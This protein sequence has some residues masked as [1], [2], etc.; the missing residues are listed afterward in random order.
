MKFKFITLAFISIMVGNVYAN[1]FN[2]E[3]TYDKDLIDKYIDYRKD[4]ILDNIEPIYIKGQKHKG[5]INYVSKKFDVPIEVFALPAIE[6]G[7]NYKARSH[8][9]AIGMWQIMKP[10]GKD[11][12][13]YISS[14]RDERRNWK[15]STVA[16]IKYLR[17]L[18]VDF[19]EG[20]YELAILA[21]N[22]G[23]GNV[24]KSMRRMNSDNAWYL[25]KNDPNLKK[26]SKEYLVKF[27]IY[28][29]YFEYLDANLELVKKNRK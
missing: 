16:A 2:Y 8:A 23:V 21:Y 29:Y 6:S 3:W 17:H 25:I 15:K 11:M 10:T 18:A 12:G 20:D 26:E 28:A 13:L 19:F 1:H 22:A 24:K 27:I 14:K 9:G 5:F 4:F 7:Y